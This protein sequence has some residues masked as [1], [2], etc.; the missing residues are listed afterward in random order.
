MPPAGP[1]SFLTCQS[2]RGA[3][4]PSGVVGITLHMPDGIHFLVRVQHFGFLLFW[5]DSRWGPGPQRPAGHRPGLS[6][7]FLPTP[8]SRVPS[9]GL[10]LASA[11]TVPSVQNASPPPFSPLPQACVCA[12]LLSTLQSG[13]AP[14]PPLSLGQPT[15]CLVKGLQRAGRGPGQGA[16]APILIGAHTASSD[17]AIGLMCEA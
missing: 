7:A 6:L 10:T 14:L 3:L 16:C 17:S 4:G 11:A 1:P 13:P 9:H 2:P 5:S 8:R 15:P 12:L